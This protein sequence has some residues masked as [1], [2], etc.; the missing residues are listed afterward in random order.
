MIEGIRI[1]SL[2]I[3]GTQF[4]ASQ[5]LAAISFVAA[6]GLLIYNHV[7]GKEST[8]AEEPEDE[9]VSGSGLGEDAE[10]VEEAEAAEELAEL[11]GAAAD[12]I[13]SEADDELDAEISESGSE[14]D[15]E[16]NQRKK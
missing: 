8:V 16:Q 7:R 9:L 5:W 11:D 10:D 1:D 12:E 13:E 14:T 2:I 6:V 3:P 4:R 15:D